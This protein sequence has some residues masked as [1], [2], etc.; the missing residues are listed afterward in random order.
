MITSGVHIIC[1]SL[2]SLFHFLRF[3]P[4]LG[5]YFKKKKSLNIFNYLFSHLLGIPFPTPKSISVLLKLTFYFEK[6]TV[7]QS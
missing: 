2:S 5:P 7:F 3:S 6:H 4:E 1:L